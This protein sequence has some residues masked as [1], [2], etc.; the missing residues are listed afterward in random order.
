MLLTDL[1]HQEIMITSEFGF[2]LIFFSFLQGDQGATGE[3]G[4]SGLQ[5]RRR[6]VDAICFQKVTHLI[7]CCW[8]LSPSGFL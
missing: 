7:E 2:Y 4:P 3:P 1:Y 6:F 5:V 8:I